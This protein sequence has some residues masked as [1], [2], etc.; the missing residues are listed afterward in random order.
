MSND[1]DLSLVNVILQKPNCA[2]F[3]NVQDLK[4]YSVVKRVKFSEN[5][6]V[7]LVAYYDRACREKI[8]PLSVNNPYDLKII[9]TIINQKNKQSKEMKIKKKTIRPHVP[10]TRKRNDV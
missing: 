6:T 9:R 7:K 2:P 3:K 5:K 1:D 10:L 4:C 8:T